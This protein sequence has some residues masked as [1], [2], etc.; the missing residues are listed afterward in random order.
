MQT[1]LPYPSFI[2][3]A[4][5]LDYRRLGKQ[6][7]EAYQILKNLIRERDRWYN[8]PAVQ[9]WINHEEALKFYYD[10]I[11]IEWIKRGYENNMPFMLVNRNEL[12]FPEWLGSK[13]FH[14]SHK[15]NLLRKNYGYYSRF[16]WNVSDDYQYVW[17]NRKDK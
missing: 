4:K 9:M 15:S 10:T 7:V 13:D 17:P 14:D 11:L 5:S 16:N 1:F 2:E 6:R 3:S 8:H 12:V